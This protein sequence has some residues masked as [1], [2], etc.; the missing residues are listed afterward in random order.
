M[1]KVLSKGTTKVV[2][3]NRKMVLDG[4]GTIKEDHNSG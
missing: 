3:I 2:K 1:G 4:Q